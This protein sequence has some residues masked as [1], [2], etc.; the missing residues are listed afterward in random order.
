MV[1]IPFISGDLLNT[2]SELL[3]KVFLAH[4]TVDPHQDKAASHSAKILHFINMTT[5]KALDALKGEL[6]RAETRWLELSA[7]Q[8]AL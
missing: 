5:T 7:M 8:E 1:L 2:D 3:G 6:A 4:T